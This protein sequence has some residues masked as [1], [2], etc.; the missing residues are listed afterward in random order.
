MLH[1]M[2]RNHGALGV[3]DKHNIS[4]SLNTQLFI[5]SQRC[6]GEH[7]INAWS[8]FMHRD[9]NFKSCSVCRVCSFLYHTEVKVTLKY[10]SFNLVRLRV[11]ERQREKIT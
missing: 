7:S 8:E 2:L 5:M 4:G 6:S 10:K 3:T 11:L 1:D 9:V